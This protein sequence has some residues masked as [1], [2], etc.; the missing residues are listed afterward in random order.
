MTIRRAELTSGRYSFN[1]ITSTSY[2]TVELAVTEAGEIVVTGP[3]NLSHVQARALIDHKAG[4]IGARLQHLVAVAAE[5]LS[6]RGPCPRCF[7]AVGSFH[8]DHCTIARCALTGL[9]RS[10][11]L[12][13]GDRCR[14]NWSGQWPGY[15]ECIE[16]GFYSRIG[17]N[18]W[19][20]CSADA[21]DAMPD[22]N[23]LYSEC[24]WDVRTQRM[25]FPDS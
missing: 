2:T 5:G 19:E 10:G 20:S 25:V 8:V 12:H 17:P 3:L 23:R 16:F 21:A 22:L 1:L 4:W 7:V 15:A 18:G 14:T 13:R 24:R 9:Q 11:C 6:A